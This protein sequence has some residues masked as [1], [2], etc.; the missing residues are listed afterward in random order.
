MEPHRFLA[1]DLIPVMRFEGE[2]GF[3]RQLT[4]EVERLAP[5]VDS[6]LLS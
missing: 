4:K 5:Q 6:I 2:A 3:R 1:E